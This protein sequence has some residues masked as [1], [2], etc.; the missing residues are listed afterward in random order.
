MTRPD[1]AAALLVRTPGRV[2][3]SAAWRNM[4]AFTARRDAATP[5]EL[6]LLEH[7]SVFTLGQAGKPEHLLNPGGIPVLQSDRGGQV[8]WH[9][10][11]QIVVYLLLDLRRLGIGPRLLVER[12]E[13]ALVATLAGFGISAVARSDAHG[14]YVPGP[15]GTLRKI[16]SLGLRIRRGCSYHGL[17]LNFDPDLEPFSRINPCGYPGL[18]MTRVVDEL[19]APP[20]RAAVEAALIAQLRAAFPPGAADGRPG[21]AATLE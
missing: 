12:I 1:A 9:G 8:T 2:D 14:V 11:G 6:W 5:D 20:A 18:A 15:D 7:H 4:Q 13:Q 3:Y 19:P 17:A 21:P 16:A 10:P